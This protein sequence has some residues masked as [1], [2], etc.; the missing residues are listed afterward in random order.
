LQ[1]DYLA[2]ISSGTKLEYRV[3]TMLERLLSNK[4]AST[5]SWRGSGGKKLAF[6]DTITKEC[7]LCKCGFMGP[8]NT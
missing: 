7:L 5:M 4:I 2:A 8:P 3:V 6:K 1:S